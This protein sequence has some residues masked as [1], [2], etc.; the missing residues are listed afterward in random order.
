MDAVTFVNFQFV[1][2]GAN[3]LSLG[4]NMFN[5]VTRVKEVK[6][7]HAR[8]QFTSSSRFL[9]EHTSKRFSKSVVPNVLRFTKA[10]SDGIFRRN[11]AHVRPQALI[12]IYGDGGELGWF[13]R[14]GHRRRGRR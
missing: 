2:E 8:F 14:W 5:L 1:D 4:G 10:K 11:E 9:I 13:R 12:A 7:A 6:Q 3:E